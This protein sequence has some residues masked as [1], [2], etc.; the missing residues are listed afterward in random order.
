MS[1]RRW[2]LI[3][4]L[5]CAPLVS[6][7]A[8]GVHG[9]GAAAKVVAAETGDAEAASGQAVQTAVSAGLDGDPCHAHG[10]ALPPPGAVLPAS[11]GAAPSAAPW[12]PSDGHPSRPERP[13]WPAARHGAPR[14]PA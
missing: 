13:N 2:L 4:L 6:A 11:R 10:V 5:L 1:V 3:L 9:A 14:Q 8:H 7:L 12:R